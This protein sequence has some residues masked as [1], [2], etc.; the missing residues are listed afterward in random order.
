MT[1]QH[2]GARSSRRSF[3]GLVGLGAA[4]VAGGPLLAGC[5]EKPAGSGTA[6]NLDAFADI[7]PAHKDLAQSIAPDIVG[8]RPVPD[9]YTKYPSNLVD[10][11]T[12]KPGSSGKEISAMTPQWGPA[13]PGLGQ[14]AYL[15]AVN[16]E[17][18]VPVNF[19]IQDG[20]TYADKL[21]AMFGG[22]DVP[23]L[24]CV[25]GWEVD[26]IPRFAEAIGVLFEDLT[27]YLK[28]DAANAYPM[29]AAF[30]TG[31]WR[32]SIWNG[33]LAA[34]PNPTDGPFPWVMFTRKDL[35]DA[36]GLTV[37]TSL[38]EL[39]A[40]AKE[41]TDP[42][43]KVWAFDDVFAMIQMYHKVPGSKGGWR[44]RS[45]GTPEFK[46]ETPEFRQALEVMA[47][48]YQDGLVHPDIIASRGADSAQLFAKN[49]AIA[50]TRAGTGM[51][52]P[53]QAEYQKVNPKLN[54]QPIPIFSAS[55]GDP[56]V[57]GDDEPISFTFVKKG[58]GKE[59][60][61]ELL[62]VINWCS[63]PLGSQEAQLRDYGVE[64]KHHTPTPNG[65]R[66]TDL[67]FK[68]IVNQYF[69]IS[70]R[71]P[72]IG[73][74]PDTPNYVQDLLTYS[75]EMVKYLEKDPWNGVK[76]EMPAAYKANQ[77]PTEDK[78]ND[79]LRGRRPISDVETIVQEWKSS[80]GEEARRLL[81]E[82]LPK[83]G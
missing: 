70:G 62:R 30:P 64:G 53:A 32:H 66:K 54:I 77:V 76:L 12:E 82:S 25:P 31:A 35:L 16:A 3:L 46:Y 27:D 20:N 1:Y 72:T 19:T 37:P 52:Q 56:L 11:I 73:P 75:N 26:K 49:G 65:P 2:S 44:L 67:A 69:F 79:V 55:G 7:L 18:G 6:Q 8:T 13:P 10:L 63:A 59:R 68:E 28:G 81:A 36:R 51:W 41:I 42:A 29:L 5:S 15:E 47:K 58:V 60:V 71:N 48:I 34:V 22:R 40:I 78:F 38:D 39:L 80:G 21:N 4:T 83:A 74:F 17:L 33:R 9:G 50:F 23:E 14:S 57:W 45:D 61:E 24:L 43:K